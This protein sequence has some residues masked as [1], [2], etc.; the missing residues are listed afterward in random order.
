M[1]IERYCNDYNETSSCETIVDQR[2]ETDQIYTYGGLRKRLELS[3]DGCE[4]KKVYRF[5]W[6]CNR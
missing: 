5:V 2:D 6:T 1:G 4:E 3:A